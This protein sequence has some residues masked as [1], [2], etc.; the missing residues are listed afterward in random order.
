VSPGGEDKPAWRREDG[1]GLE[2][3]VGCR[4][5]SA[6]KFVVSSVPDL[7]FRSP[8]LSPFVLSL[9]VTGEGSW[10]LTSAST[11]SSPAFD[12]RFDLRG[13]LVS[14]SSAVEPCE[15]YQCL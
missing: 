11:L 12:K 6:A 5:S 8:S 1:G 7:S 2:I 3:G 9:P 15:K 10:P 14:A 13:F 4:K